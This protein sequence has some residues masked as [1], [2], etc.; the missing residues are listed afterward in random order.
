MSRIQ[1]LS[2]AK[3]AFLTS[4]YISEYQEFQQ[5]SPGLTV[6]WADKLSSMVS[7][8]GFGYDY[9]LLIKLTH[10][11]Q[12]LKDPVDNLEGDNLNISAFLCQNGNVHFI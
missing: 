3:S 1:E 2:T 5:S 9:T 10:E 4:L 6:L 7:Y 8:Q 12:R 11:S